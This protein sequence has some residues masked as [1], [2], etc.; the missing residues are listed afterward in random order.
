MTSKIIFSTLLLVLSWSI[1]G[2]AKT[3]SIIPFINLISEIDTLPRIDTISWT[4]AS[5]AGTAPPNLYVDSILIRKLSLQSERF[6]TK[7][8]TTTDSTK[9]FIFY[10]NNQREKPDTGR[11]N[12]YHFLIQI[13][14]Q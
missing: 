7:N 3:A 4:V 5:V 13:T 11:I 6:S 8:D 12:T 2:I 14:A 9:S 1:K 10:P